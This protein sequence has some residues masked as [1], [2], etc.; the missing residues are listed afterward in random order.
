MNRL[1]I[2]A[3]T[4]LL[5]PSEAQITPDDRQEKVKTV[6]YENGAF[7][8]SSIV[9]DGGYF[10]GGLVESYSGVKF[11]ASDWPAIYSY[12]ASRTR[13]PVTGL[14]GAAA[15]NCR[16]VL[17]GWTVSK[18]FGTVTADLEVWRV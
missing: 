14:D 3:V 2:G 7:V 11:K 15:D 18:H 9:V 5:S 8:P 17:R 1:I 10:P 4:A 16:I 13:V 6:S 12:W